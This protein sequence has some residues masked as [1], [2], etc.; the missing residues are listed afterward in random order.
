MLAART[1]L[2]LVGG[3]FGVLVGGPA[4]LGADPVSFTRDV[5]PIL[6]GNCLKCHGFDPST[7]RAKLRLDRFEHATAD[8]RG[9][10]AIVPGDAA[11][12][13]LLARVSAQ[14]PDERMPPEGE[15][16]SAAEIDVLRRWIDEGA[17]YDVHWSLRPVTNPEVPGVDDPAWAEH[18]IDAFVCRRQIDAGIVAPPRADRRV[19]LRRLSFDLTGLPPT[20]EQVDAFLGDD[21]PDAYER[22]VD[23]LLASPRFG[24]R[25]ARHWLD[26]V[27]YAET[28][29][30]EFDYPIAHAW[31]YRDYVIRALNADVPYD[32]FVTEHIAGDL[33]AEPRRH[34]E[35]GYDESIIGT[36]FWWLSQ[37]THAPVDVRQDEADRIDN[38]LD[39]LS[40]AFL[41][42]TVSCA[43]C[44]DHKFDPITQA[45]YYAL[46]GFLQ[47]SRRQHAYL[48]PDGRIDDAVRALDTLVAPL[49][50]RLDEA[51]A[52]RD[53]GEV[54]RA[55]L[56][57]AAE[58][59]GGTPAD[60][61]QPHRARDVVL[62]EDWETDGAAFGSVVRESEHTLASTEFTIGHDHVFLEIGGGEHPEQARARL[63][64]DGKPVRTADGRGA[65]E[66]ARRHW[67][68]SELRGEPAR[69]ELA[70]RHVADRAAPRVRRVVFS[71]EGVPDR[72]RRR[73][74]AVVAEERG[75]D[76]G[77]LAQWTDAVQRVGPDDAAHPLHA[78]AVL[79]ATAPGQRAPRL[80]ALRN[81]ARAR[82]QRADEMRRSAVPLSSFVDGLPG[83]FRS[84]WAF[85]GPGVASG[86]WIAPAERLERSDAAFADS[87]TRADRLMGTLRSPTFEITHP[88]LH[89]RAR[90]RGFV[91]VIVDGYTMDEYNPLLFGGA[92]QRIDAGDWTWRAH[93]LHLY[94]G[95][96]AHYEIIDDEDGARLAVAEIRFADSAELPPAGDAVPAWLDDDA[97]AAVADLARVYGTQVAAAFGPDPEPAP[98]R[99]AN[100]LLARQLIGPASDALAEARVEATAVLADLPGPMRV[101]AIEDGPGEDE[102]VAL[103]GDPHSPGALAPRA[104]VAMLAGD[105]T[106][107]PGAGSGRLELARTLLA[108]DNPMPARVMVNRV[109]HHLLG[110]GIVP[111][112][113][114]F[115]LLGQVPSDPELLD[116]LAHRFRTEMDWSIKRLVREIVT[117]RTYRARRVPRR[118]DGEAMRDAILAISGR[119]DETMYGPSVAIHLSDF[120]QGRGRPGRS[121]P[122]D[123]AG[124]RSVYL[125]VR[126]NFLSPM[127]Q[128]FDAP[129][130]HSTMG[131]R[132]R[133]NVPA[134][135]LILMND[136]FVVAEAKRLAERL[137]AEHADD[138]ERLEH[139]YRLALAR[140]PNAG[141]ADALR[142]FLDEQ[143][144]QYGESVE[145][146][147]AAAW[148][149]ACHVV[150][151]LKEFTFIE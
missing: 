59:L 129:V 9:G 89:V 67:D 46:A 115:G 3:A 98:V 107:D 83:W 94:V 8:R 142:A 70:D 33:V 132:V 81:E 20:P 101:L 37:G 30:H 114:D 100:W 77:A 7:R 90:G 75:L 32:R 22:V 26:L 121:G 68:V 29:A 39:V 127:M 61:E 135:S 119:L 18:A 54:T 97:S 14:D 36:G 147:R 112:T 74:P 12:S 13:P 151:N 5:R 128:A 48:D 125:E 21:R 57:A 92:R 58:V 139:L 126:R 146:P 88:F 52:A 117:S 11:A 1:R 16:L 28:Y 140:S 44:H 15:P 62:Y 60:G 122:A 104:F 144:R 45:E 17:S 24:E 120:M 85:V 95:H 71:D 149:D 25:W 93:D 99:L 150:M 108:A 96:R 55:M 143:T 49:S 23:D 124:R 35:H 41:A 86:A 65:K 51:M 76:A 111:T 84:G 31:Q 19:L 136:P 79:V 10:P 50:A 145:D 109:W 38:Q 56:L 34:P 80:A 40:K 113:D 69:L 64:I 78:F 6:V 141:E 42:T 27:R 82:G 72:P 43:R 73:D 138:A 102:H 131:C 130:P 91:R 134:Q 118:L 105:P 106:I 116:H 63:I 148:A 137:H 110:T 2:G 4:T 53:P 87:G 133:S 123:G 47:S 66:P 103:R